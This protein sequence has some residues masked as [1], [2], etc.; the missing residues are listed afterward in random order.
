MTT[1]T[2]LTIMTTVITFP[3]SFFSAYPITGNRLQLLARL[4]MVG[5]ISSHGD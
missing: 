2:T 3:E 4:T 5:V 1:M